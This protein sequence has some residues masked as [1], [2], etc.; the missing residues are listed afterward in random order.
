MELLQQTVEV[1]GTGIPELTAQCLQRNENKAIYLRSDGVYEV[2]KIKIAPEEIVFGKTYPE[3]ETYPG[4]EDFGKT[5]WCYR[6]KALAWQ[7]YR[8]IT[9]GE[10]MEKTG[11]LD[12]DVR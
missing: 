11:V 2:F 3:R 12:E 1:K 4:N 9:Q 8:S 10:I 5:A 6:N 7:K